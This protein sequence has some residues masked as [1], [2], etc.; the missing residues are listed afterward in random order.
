MG[1][2]EGLESEI[3]TILEELRSFEE[4]YK[5]ELWSC[6]ISRM[7]IELSKGSVSDVGN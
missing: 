1:F 6:N 2:S 7:Y 4:S 5:R 3:G